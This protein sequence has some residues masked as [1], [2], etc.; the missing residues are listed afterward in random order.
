MR[1]LELDL[2]LLPALD[3]KRLVLDRVRRAL[4]EDDEVVVRRAL[5]AFHRE[6]AA[7]LLLELGE[8]LR[9]GADERRGDLRVQLDVECLAPRAGD[10]PADAPLRIDG[11]SL[12]R[13]DDAVALA[14]G[15]DVR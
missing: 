8:A 5:A 2:E 13:H 10:Q 6:A 4:L 9:A 11:M 3:G 12:H 14:G 1:L 7:G 15:A